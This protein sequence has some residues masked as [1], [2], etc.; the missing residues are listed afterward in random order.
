MTRFT[1]SAQLQKTRSFRQLWYAQA[2]AIAAMCLL[3]AGTSLLSGCKLSR[4]D[5]S[6]DSPA[7]IVTQFYNWRIESGTT[8]VPDSGQ[9]EDM[10]PWL[11]SELQALL[12]DTS[13]NAALQAAQQAARK[14]SNRNKKPKKPLFTDGDLFSSIS[15]GPTSFRTGT[16]EA[17]AND[18][19]VIPVRFV[20]GR[21]L[22]AINWTDRVRVIHENGHYVV[23]D[24]QY[25]NHWQA[26]DSSLLTALKQSKRAKRS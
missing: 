3:M 6:D 8:G 14:Q 13:R 7:G 20:S 23:A 11:S 5:A 18:A 15:Q 26:G 4:T 25:A 12:Q 21:Q 9:I 17:Q 10:R 19:H 1:A 16:V 2:Y 22:P 24:V